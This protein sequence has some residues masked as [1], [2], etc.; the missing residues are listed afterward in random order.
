MPLSYLCFD[1]CKQVVT[2]IRES[3]RFKSMYTLQEKPDRHTTRIPRSV[4]IWSQT[5][6][7]SRGQCIAT[8]HVVPI[9]LKQAPTT[10]R[11]LGDKKQTDPAVVLGHLILPPSQHPWSRGERFRLSGYTTISSYWAHI[12][13]CDWYVQY[14]LAG[15]NSSVLNR[16]R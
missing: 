5:I 13:A 11:N 16:H 4:H 10:G 9:R 6:R 1:G 8:C 2:H 7:I 3:R 15:A 14:F 12:P